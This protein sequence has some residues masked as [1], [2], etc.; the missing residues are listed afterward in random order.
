MAP[1][2]RAAVTI[3]ALSQLSA[4]ANGGTYLHV[5]KRIGGP[6]VPV[7]PAGCNDSTGIWQANKSIPFGAGIAGGYG[8]MDWLPRGCS[9][10]CRCTVHR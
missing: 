6:Y 3:I 9:T 1:P 10:L 2:F 7:I 4:T 5:S 8:G